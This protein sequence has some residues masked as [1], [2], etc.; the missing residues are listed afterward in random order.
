MIAA[1][2]LAAVASATALGDTVIDVTYTTPT[3]DRWNYPFNPTP[4]IRPTAS[5]FGNAAGS[6][7]FDNLDGQMIVEWDTNSD[8]PTGRV[9]NS[10]IVASM[11]LT[12]EFASDLA[13]QYDDTTDP[14]QSF[15][16]PK[17]PAYI[18]DRDPGQPI[19]LFGTGFRN[20]YSLASWQETSPYAPA[21]ANLLSP[22]VRN[23]FALGFSDSG[24][25]LDVS[26]SVR[27]MFSPTPFATGIVASVSLG[28]FIPIGA[29]CVFDV[30]IDNPVVQGY[31]QQGLATGKV[32]LS[33]TSLARVVQQGSVFPSF[34]CKENP[35]V[36]AGLAKAAK[37]HMTVLLIDC[38]PVDFNCD[39][40]VGASDLGI[41]LGAWGSTTQPQFD[42]SGDGIVG[43][44][45]LGI[46]LGAW[47]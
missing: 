9:P 12:L 37:L 31:L 21:G 47:G 42:L 36:A 34:Y 44:E 32:S 45:D 20:G 17:D 13:I 28:D 25:F 39:G 11:K 33:V 41:L 3:A 29:E 38:A 19:E 4:G 14:W 27:D 46:L 35:L 6:P 22:G 26:N 40:V 24:K 1:L 18:A 30:A 5:V 23:A 7:L 43:A 15:L 16:L 2:G 10:Y 8:V